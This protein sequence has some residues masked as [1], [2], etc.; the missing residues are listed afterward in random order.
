MQ[1]VTQED[2]PA[3]EVAVS[4]AESQTQVLLIGPAPSEMGGMA[5]V[6]EQMLSL[7]W[8]SRFRVDLL[9][10]TLSS[11]DHEPCHSRLVRH[12]TQVRRLKQTIDE[13]NV[14]IV[15]IHTCSGM[16]FFRSAV[17]LLIAK[18]A[19]C[20]TILHIH[21]ASFDAFYDRIG[22]MG[23]YMVSKT[24]SAAGGVVALSDAWKTK[25][26]AM[27]P[28][29]KIAVIENAVAIP[30][31]EPRA[32][33][34]A[35]SRPS[36]DVGPATSPIAKGGR[37][38]VAR[39]TALSG[40]RAIKACRFLLLARMDD[41]KGI[42]DLL[43]AA[44]VVHK[45][46]HQFKVTLAGP[47]GSAGD[48]SVLASKIAN[49]GLTGIVTYIGPVRGK[50]KDDLLRATDVYIQPS[51]HEGM[52]ISLLE[53]LAFGLP[54]V[55]TRVG[56]VPEVITDGHEGL[57]V[58][59]HRPDLLANAMTRAIADAPG[60]SAMS[61]AAFDLATARFSL[62]RFTADLLTLYRQHE[63]HIATPDSVRP[64]ACADRS[65]QSG[66]TGP[67]VC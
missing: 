12:I 40:E 52:P 7:D 28:G 49:R 27:A 33:A 65:C 2:V 11:D 43:D 64:R 45:A 35:A 46:G 30:M 19:G 53:A 54:I 50:A 15:H 32:S 57:L 18:Q 66:Q 5:S 6:I 56:A 14:R 3:R 47:S 42:D 23:K 10:V 26:S 44:A 41:W 21:G 9:P 67:V 25:L 39:A 20:R 37:R 58:P 8:P 13:R 48:E 62:E 1:S 24:L 55:A 31:P 60:R 17:D 34:R 63:R 16:S 38:G 59:A 29:A 4:D 61:K 22:A 36:C 51:H